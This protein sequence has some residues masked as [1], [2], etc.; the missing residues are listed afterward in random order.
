MVKQSVSYWLFTFCHLFV[1][2]RQSPEYLFST[3][4]FTAVDACGNGA[5]E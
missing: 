2:V 3:F 5:L 1:F 4:T